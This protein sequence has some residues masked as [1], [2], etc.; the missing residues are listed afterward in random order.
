MFERILFSAIG[1]LLLTI[2]GVGVTAALQH[3]D[4]VAALVPEA[5]EVVEDAA[6]SATNTVV[7]VVAAVFDRADISV[8][9]PPAS[10]QAERAEVEAKVET[11]E[12]A[13]FSSRDLEDEEECD[14]DED[15]EEGDDEDDDDC[16][17]TIVSN[18]SPAAAPPPQSAPAPA[19]ASPSPQPSAPVSGVHTFTMAEVAAH[20]SAASCYSAINGSVY[21][22]TSFING[23]PGGSAAIKS[24]C[25]V[26][27]TAAFNAQH[28][29]T[30][31]PAQMLA[32]FKI[33]VLAQ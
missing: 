29:G 7:H 28:G 8:D 16:A 1:F 13:V 14:W 9:G 32:S 4:E 24:L 18:V 17:R 3:P 25:G 11:R 12:S 31:K 23:H 30:G 6:G 19:P 33:G 10:E 20:A 22:L 26:D 5:I 15:D 27:G 2:T 21:D